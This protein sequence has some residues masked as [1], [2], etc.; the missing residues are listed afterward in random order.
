M[1]FK[2]ILLL[3]AI[4]ALLMIALTSAQAGATA[5]PTTTIDIAASPYN[6][7]FEFQ[8]LSGHVVNEQSMSNV[9]M[10]NATSEHRPPF[11]SLLAFGT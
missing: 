2:E 1:R 7:L 6:G 4:V 5:C 3:K 11:G 10:R 8:Q 9:K